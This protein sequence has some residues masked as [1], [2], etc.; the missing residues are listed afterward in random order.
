[1]R[2][3]SM[4]AAALAALCLCCVLPAAALDYKLGPLTIE[5]PW[6]RPTLPGQVVAGAYLGIR[7]GGNAGDRLLGASMAAARVEVHE[8]R[9]EG[10]VMRMREIGS[11]ELPAGKTVTLAPGGY[12]LMLMDLK[13]P[14]KVGE[15]IPIKL[16]FERAGE[17]DVVLQV[18][19]KP[20]SAADAHKH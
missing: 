13:S 16:R 10:D 15:T 3:I 4:R 1:M 19:T 8:M 18:E 6:A 7:N 5:H 9:M 11:L 20:A 14:L 2:S 12:H 17:V